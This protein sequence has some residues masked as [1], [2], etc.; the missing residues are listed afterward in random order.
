MARKPPSPIAKATLFLPNP[1]QTAT[2]KKSPTRRYLSLTHSLCVTKNQIVVT[3][4]TSGGLRGEK[5]P[6]HSHCYGVATALGHFSPLPVSLSLSIPY[7]PL[8]PSD[9]MSTGYNSMPYGLASVSAAHGRVRTTRSRGR[10]EIRPFCAMRRSA[11]SSIHLAAM[12][13][14]AQGSGRGQ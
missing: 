1:Q 3:P 12:L 9:S 13:N 10:A 14:R 4:R 6:I 8:F 11:R 2:K 5:N 7:P